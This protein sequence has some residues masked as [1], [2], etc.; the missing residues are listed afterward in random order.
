M[1]HSS[2]VKKST[3]NLANRITIGRILLIPV[4]VVLVLYYENAPLGEGEWIRNLAITVF[5]FAVLTDAVDGF[6]ARTMQQKT[7]LGTFLDPIADKLLITSAM[8]ILSFP[9]LRLGYQLP[10]WFIVLVISRDMIITM[11][12]LLIHIL[13]GSVKVVP[14]IAG[15]ITT[16]LQMACVFA[17]LLKSSWSP[18]WVYAA[19]LATLISGVDYI[20]FGSRQLSGNHQQK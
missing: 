4:F 20:L 2:E 8:V 19:A 6:I 14:S 18:Y 17:I 10:L 7:P 13:N 5:G 15:K 1:T 12:A 3:L 11:G 16:G 9:H